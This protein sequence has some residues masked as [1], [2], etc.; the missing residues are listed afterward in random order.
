MFKKIL[1]A[2]RGEIA[3]RI[4]RAC[5]EMEISTVAVYSEIDRTAGHV[6]YA[7]EAYLLGPAPAN[8][9]YLV[10]EKI[11]KAAIDSKAEAIHPGYG[12]LAENPEFAAEVKRNGLVFI[13][14]E[15]ETIRLLGDK[16]SARETMIKAGVPIVPGLE[17]AASTYLEA[18]EQA[19]QIG[20][21]ILLKAAAGGGGKGM[22]IVN[23]ANEI[24]QLF[25]MARSE[26]KS[27]F[28]DDRIYIEKYIKNPRHIEFQIF[29]DRHGNIV[30]LG[31]R[32]CSIQRRHQ[33]VIEESPSPII[34]SDPEMRERMGK[35]AI[36]AANAADYINA[37]TVEFL[38]DKDK[39]F[40]FLEV[41]TRLQVEHPVTELVTGLDLA[42][43]QIR[44]ANGEK[45]SFKQD[46]IKMR[47]SSIECRIYAEDPENNFLPSIGLIQSY[48]EPNGPGVRVD[49]G[50]SKGDTISI[51]YDPLISKLVTWGK[52]RSEAIQRMKRALAEYQISGVQTVI[53]F[54]KKVMDQP[55]F[56]SGDFSTH[57]IQDKMDQLAQTNSISE[58]DKKALAIISCLFD[59]Q[60]KKKNRRII[61]KDRL[62][63]WK[64]ENRKMRLSL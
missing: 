31:E 36:K 51:Y 16:M 38:V 52:D 19:N 4:M 8:E 26:A 18:R 37:G 42:K 55:N 21:P 13:G 24:E 46:E 58:E 17:Q 56:L 30:H 60:S 50:F 62:S 64:Y 47:G 10:I 25:K 39:N 35:A 45:L 1:I 63:C 23:S 48:R 20:Y 12:F 6:R 27:A 22:R 40:Y 53:P 59:F 11:I 34:D 5:K 32:E 28:G 33:K 7:D 57:F 41:N 54:H 29:A 9:S 44:I 43:E 14:P 61:K 3:I 2:N 15:P 49:S